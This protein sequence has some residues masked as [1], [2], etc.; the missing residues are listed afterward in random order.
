ML[1][2]ISV[3]TIIGIVYTSRASNK[4]IYSKGGKYIYKGESVNKK[5]FAIYE[6]KRDFIKAGSVTRSPN[7]KYIAAIETSRG[8]ISPETKDYSI[9]PKNDL[10]ILDSTGNLFYLVDDDV[11]KY[12]WSPDGG[13]IAYITGTY[14]EGGVGFKTT[15]VY[16]LD[17]KDGS[18]RKI[19]K[20]FPSPTV[21]DFEGGGF[22]INWAIHDRNIYVQEFDYLG[23]NYM[24]DTKTGKTVRVPYKGIYFSPDGEYY[25]SLSTEDSPRLYITTNNQEITERVESRFGYLPQSWITDQGHQ[26][27]IVKIDYE[28]TPHDA[29]APGKPQAMVKGVRKI[30]QKTLFIYD[31]EKDKIVKQWTEK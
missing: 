15:G 21:K 24:Y 13:K 7:H 26:M 11:R 5:E 30:R 19:T 12:S 14:Y 22:D 9:L 4:E 25:L 1:F 3:L 28:P 23:G 8:T 27:L 2:L 16:I 17:L 18:K 10:V 31:V 29:L 20:D 6:T